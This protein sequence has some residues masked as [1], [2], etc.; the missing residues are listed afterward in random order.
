VSGHIGVSVACVE[1]HR[2]KKP[3]GRS[4]PLAMAGGLCDQDCDGYDLEPLVGCLW[5]SET[6]ED[7]GYEHCHYGSEPNRESK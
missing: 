1:C 6:C 3:H 5:W 4:A 2:S 7:F